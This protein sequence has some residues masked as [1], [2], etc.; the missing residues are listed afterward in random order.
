[1]PCATLEG[2]RASRRKHYYNN[3]EQYRT[4][5]REREASIRRYLNEAKSV[6]CKDCGIRYPPWVVDFDHL[7]DKEFN[8]ATAVKRGMGLNRLAREIAKC[9]VVCSNCHRQRTH[10]RLKTQ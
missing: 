4:K 2:A 9:D 7:G 1:M 3:K 10:D 8:I 6:P 5:A